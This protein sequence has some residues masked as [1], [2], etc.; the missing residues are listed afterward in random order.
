LEGE[1]PRSRNAA[2]EEEEEEEDA[3]DIGTWKAVVVKIESDAKDERI[4]KTVIAANTG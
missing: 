2:D 3:T 4:V 1:R